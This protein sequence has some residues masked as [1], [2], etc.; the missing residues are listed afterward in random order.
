M[1]EIQYL[2]IL[3]NSF[4]VSW[5]NKFLWFFGFLIL[6]GSV[7]ENLNLNKEDLMVNTPVAELLKQNEKYSLL[8]SFFLLVG[9]V[10][11]YVLRIL[12]SVA[13]IRGINNPLLYKQLK[14]WAVLAEARNYLG[15]LIILDCL[16][17]FGAVAIILILIIPIA[18]LFSFKALLFGLIVS[19]AALLI[20]IPLIFL[21]FFLKKFSFM[22]ITLGGLKIKE[23]L[24][25]SYE[26]CS[27]QLKQILLMGLLVLVTGLV[28]LIL[29]TL[30]AAPLLIANFIRPVDL[31]SIGALGSAGVVLISVVSLIFSFYIVFVQVVW[32][33]FFSQISMQKNIES[34][35][36]EENVVEKSEVLSPD[37]A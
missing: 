8:V 28:L 34:Q 9:L 18:L 4:L 33:D 25:F 19:F 32:L 20:L 30:L 37:V 29:V 3:K 27:R 11:F 17:D 24:E 2:I 12:S 14:P 1:Q 21:L 5:K 23:A 15:R 31:W 36:G 16:L 13:L 35:L 26:I 6:L 10:F 7:F 22:V